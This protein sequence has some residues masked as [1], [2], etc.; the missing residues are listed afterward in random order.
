MTS[1]RQC[2]DTNTNIIANI[3][4][5]KRIGKNLYKKLRLIFDEKIDKNLELRPIFNEKIGE[6]LYKKLWLTL[7]KKISKS[8]KKMLKTSFI[9]NNI[10]FKKKVAIFI[11]ETNTKIYEPKI[12]NE[13]IVNLI[14]DIK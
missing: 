8:L 7:A 10:H 11:L 3:L 4:N 6:N 1:K 14:Y 2:L 12:Y 9:H 13:I 5:I